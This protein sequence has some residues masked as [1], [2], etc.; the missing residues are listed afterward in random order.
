MPEQIQRIINRIVEWWKQFTKQQKVLIIS[1]AAVVVV[2]LSIL[3]FAVTRPTWITIATAENA[4]Q[5]KTI[6]SLLD[7]ESIT[8]QVSADG[9]TYSIHEEDRA[10]AV[11]ALGSNGIPSEGYSIEDALGGG[12]ATTE[13]DKNKKYQVYLEKQW[14]KD[15]EGL[16]MVDHA[17]VTLS[18]PEYDGTLISQKEDT[19]ASVRLT[20]GASMDTD[21]ASAIAKSI[22]TGIG[23][24]TT[25]HITIIDS[26]GNVLFSGG[27]EATAAGIAANNQTVKRDAERVA[28]NKIKSILAGSNDGST[29]F[30]N[31]RVEAN[32][33]MD[34]SDTEST[35]YHYYVD[36]GMSQGYLDSY[37]ESISK[38]TNGVAG[39]PGTDSNDDTTYVMQDNATSESSTSDKVYDYLPSETVTTTKNAVG[40]V[41]YENSSISVV[42]YNNVV[43]NEDT[44]KKNGTLGDQTFDE[45][46]EANKDQVRKEVD[47]DIINAISTATNI[48]V[49]NITVIAYDQPLFQYSESAIDLMD[50]LQIVIAVLILAM[51]GFVVFRSLRVEKEEEV[52]EE[53]S[54]EDLLEEQEQEN[55]E[56]IGFSEKSETR[57]L[58]E[59]FVD[60]NPEA[61]AALLRN[62]L[63]EDWGG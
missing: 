27:D 30:D 12:L 61:V 36:E 9:M 54:V 2:A 7:G 63:N 22:A 11:I 55:L 5:S 14:E 16:S 24:N 60:E 57:I 29:L 50:I 34:F 52:A 10:R 21:Q 42:A 28:A 38:N 18:I 44:M 3:A 25:E 45:F 41:D 53:I 33:V 31:V 48:P 20:L 49:A 62:W 23:N 17:E 15:L 13:A 1:A 35:D 19:Y 4:T 56:D 47:D 8:Y 46:V 51:L 26:N 58:I 40:N 32:L 39:V 43:Y 59:K 37:S 6:Q